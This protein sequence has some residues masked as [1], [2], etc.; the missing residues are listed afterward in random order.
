MDYEMGYDW[1]GPQFFFPTHCLQTFDYQKGNKQ[2]SDKIGL[3]GQGTNITDSVM[4]YYRA[5]T[6]TIRK[7]ARYLVIP[8][9][10]KEN[11]TN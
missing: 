9:Y 8:N 11:Y 10:K 6:K 3:I 2:F 7:G 4:A 5:I 1:G